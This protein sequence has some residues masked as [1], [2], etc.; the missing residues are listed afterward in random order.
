MKLEATIAP[1][2]DG[3]VIA[4]YGETA[5]IFRP[6][7]DGWIVCDIDN[8]EHVKALLRT[9]NFEPANDSDIQEA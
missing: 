8:I 7:S 2:K 1:R 3:T 5:Y 6:D 4:R 9:G